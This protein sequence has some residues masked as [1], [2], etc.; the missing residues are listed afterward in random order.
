MD[1]IFQ[2][3]EKQY[4]LYYIYEVGKVCQGICRCVC[5]KSVSEGI[6]VKDSQTPP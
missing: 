2:T 6:F 3:G 1:T 4:S 5:I